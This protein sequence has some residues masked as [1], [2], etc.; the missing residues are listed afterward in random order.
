MLS[1]IDLSRNVLGALLIL[2]L[3]SQAKTPIITRTVKFLRTDAP[4]RVPSPRSQIHSYR[5][6]PID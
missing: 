1:G 5:S 3:R 4:R 6:P 2:R